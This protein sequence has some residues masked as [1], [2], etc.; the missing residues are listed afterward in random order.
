MI[1]ID[2]WPLWDVVE[3]SFSCTWRST[4]FE[5]SKSLEPLVEV[6]LAGDFGVTGPGNRGSSPMRSLVAVL[7]EKSSNQKD[8]ANSVSTGSAGASS[9]AGIVF[10]EPVLSRVVCE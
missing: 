8:S 7:V 2:G 9:E 5:A 1:G 6:A 4:P 3:V 10:G